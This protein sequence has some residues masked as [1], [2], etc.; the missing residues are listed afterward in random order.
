MQALTHPVKSHPLP[1]MGR[2]TALG[3]MSL[4]FSFT[5]QQIK[6]L[7]PFSQNHIRIIWIGIRDQDGAFANKRILGGTEMALKPRASRKSSV[8]L[9][10]TVLGAAWEAGDL[11]TTRSTLPGT[12]P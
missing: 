3:H 9:Q 10:G 4:C 6:L 7:F 12:E 8:C 2:I 1:V 5:S 11:S